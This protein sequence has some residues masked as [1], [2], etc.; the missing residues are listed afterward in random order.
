VIVAGLSLFAVALMLSAFFSGSET[1]FYRASRVRWVLDGMEGDRVSKYFL[2]LANNPPLYVGTS[3]VG[4]NIANYLISLS[5]VL[6]AGAIAPNSQAMEIIA[7]LLLT[8]A[9]F[10]YGELLPKNLFYLAPNRLLRRLGPIYL[11]FFVLFLPIVGLL[12]VFGRFLERLLGQ[13]PEKIRLTLA[14]SELNQILKEGEVVG[15]LHPSQRQM[16]QSFFLIAAKPV[17]QLCIPLPRV[18]SL[19][20][21]TPIHRAISYAQRFRLPHVVI[22]DG[23][24]S[25]VVGY[26]RTVDLILA[27]DTYAAITEPRELLELYGG[28]HTGE[29][30]MRMQTRRFD[31]AKV[32]NPRNQVIGIVSL[33]EL[34]DP[35]F[36][37][38]TG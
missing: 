19:P 12:F 21:G 3:L 18:H 36:K 32:L 35:L 27:P 20:L 37:P 38:S 6:V 28:E 1:G 2:A 23:S 5:I 33:N 17:S 15:I 16:S 24:K 13:S 25:N 7:P 30:I 34:T 11:L 26:V 9:V 31:L 22:H 4:N 8:P 14:R 29:A 10:V